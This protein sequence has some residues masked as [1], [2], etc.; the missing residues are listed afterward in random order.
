MPFGIFM[1]FL[2]VQI[3]ENSEQLQK[4]VSGTG[5][6]LII[7]FITPHSKKLICYKMLQSIPDS[8]EK[9]NGAL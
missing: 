3:S 4:N 9:S 6:S 5:L 2:Q 8:D 1:M 7:L